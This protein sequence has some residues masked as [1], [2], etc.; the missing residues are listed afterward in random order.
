MYIYVYVYSIHI[1]VLYTDIQLLYQKYCA[2]IMFKSLAFSHRISHF[3]QFSL[4][5]YQMEDV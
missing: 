1:Y 4:H 3:L 5:P 2:E